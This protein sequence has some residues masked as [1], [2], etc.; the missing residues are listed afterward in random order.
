MNVEAE[1]AVKFF[2]F[3]NLGLPMA[4]FAAAF[5]HLRLNSTKRARLFKEFVPWAMKCGSSSQSLITVYW[6]ERWEQNM[7]EL[8]KELAWAHVAAKETVI[9]F[10]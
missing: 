6:E 7:D 9:I 3:A 8:K 5:G 10:F 2:E 1:L 4:G